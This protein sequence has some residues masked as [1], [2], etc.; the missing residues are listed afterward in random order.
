[1]VLLSQTRQIVSN[2]AGRRAVRALLPSGPPPSTRANGRVVVASGGL[3][4]RRRFLS[5]LPHHLEADLLALVEPVQTCGVH[6]SDVDEHVLRAVLR[7]NEAEALG[8]VEP[9]HG[10]HCHQT[11][12]FLPRG[13]Y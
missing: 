2:A 9:L 12:S 8:G 7:L 4:V 10:T 13:R 1:M 5:A 3:E 11:L 6:G